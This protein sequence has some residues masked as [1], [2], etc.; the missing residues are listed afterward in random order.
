[1]M[2]FVLW[3]SSNWC[4]SVTT[5]MM[6]VICIG[7]EVDCDFFYALQLSGSRLISG[8]LAMVEVFPIFG[9]LRS[10]MSS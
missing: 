5:V 4:S 6:M 3:L 10:F 7:V 9:S 1:M 2:L 8:A